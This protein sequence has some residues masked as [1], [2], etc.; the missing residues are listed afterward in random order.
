MKFEAITFDCWGTLLVDADWPTTYAIRVDRL[1]ASARP[2]RVV[3][4]EEARSALDS[5]WRN[6]YQNWE[7]GHPSGAVEMAR[8]ALEILIDSPAGP[9]QESRTILAPEIQ[10][11]ASALAIEFTNATLEADIRPVA[12]S[13][14]L[15]ESLHRRGLRL[16]MICDTGFATGQ[17]VRTLLDRAGLLEWLTTSIFSDEWG[18]PKPH[19]RLFWA[20]LAALEVEPNRAAHVGD[21]D[22]TDVRGAK[23]A[24]MTAIRLTAHHDD[25][26]AGRDAEVVVVDSHETLQDVLLT[27]AGTD[28][29]RGD[30]RKT[31]S[32]SR[33][34]VSMPKASVTESLDAASPSLVLRDRAVMDRIER[35]I[36]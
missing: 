30:G 31:E 26:A 21:L 7:S 35:L 33:E 16:G 18:V 22:R 36:R 9:A 12:G 29:D 13:R 6:H 28:G 5:A 19:P 32:G 14:V 24:G 8:E 34:A 3:T 10:T 2:F 11:A 23:R 20:A 27:S 17:T 25:P 1:A 15:L 4:P